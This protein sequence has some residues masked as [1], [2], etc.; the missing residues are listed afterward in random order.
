MPLSDVQSQ[1]RALGILQSALAKG[2]LH[3]AYLFAG[4]DGVGK[5]MA[6]RAFAQALVCPVEPNVGCGRCQT[7]GR[8]ARG[9]HPDV[10]LLLSEELQIARGLLAR[11]DLGRAPS[12]DLRVEQVRGLQESLARRPLE[13]SRR[14]ALVL[15]AE[16]LNDAAQNAFLKTLE[17]P[18]P[19]TVLVLVT[20]APHL[21]LPTMRSRLALVP[22]G[23]LPES[24]VA[25]KLLELEG[26]APETAE[27]A[28]HLAEGS[29]GTALRLD[30]EALA[31]R[32]AVIRGFEAL[33]GTDVR[34]LL[35]FAEA[36]GKER[37][38][39]EAALHALVSW[40]AELGRVQAGEAPPP[41]ALGPLA[42]ARASEV[43]PHVLH[44][45]QRLYAAALEA[46]S[47]RNAAPRLQLEGLLLELFA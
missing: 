41:G 18:P 9:N 10:H 8:V 6:A 37:A 14:L 43:R 32:E 19:D 29:V 13:A 40:N 16:A 2:Q 33:G 39:A 35:R 22:F 34:P 38:G 45:R 3:H 27:L 44:Q 23:P 46:I 5:E 17:E 24:F 21:L 4:P 1:P 31:Q 20:S 7:C 15:G 36:Y 26:T 42:K 28:A 47:E 25:Q 30:A 12:R 11:S